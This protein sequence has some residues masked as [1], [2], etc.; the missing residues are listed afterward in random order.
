MCVTESLG[1]KHFTP[2]R[3]RASRT[4]HAYASR[5]TRAGGA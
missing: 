4:L 1:L 3:G 5:A 2:A